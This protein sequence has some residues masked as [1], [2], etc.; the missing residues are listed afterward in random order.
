MNLKT[1]YKHGDIIGTK[2]LVH[3]VVAGGVG[4]VYFCLDLD[5]Q[6]P[7][8]LKTFQRQFLEEK[9]IADLFVNE[10]NIWIDL[11]HH[12]N[13]VYCISVLRM[14]DQVFI[15]LEWISNSEKT[16]D[17]TLRGWINEGPFPIRRA[18]DFMID[19]CRGLIHANQIEPSI[20]HCDLKPENIL[21]SEGNVAK[22][23]DWGL[24]KVLEKARSS[25]SSQD[26]TSSRRGRLINYAGIWGTPLYMSPEQWRGE[27]VDVRS[28]IY[29]LGC[30]LYEMLAGTPPFHSADIKILR[31]QHL[32]DD[33]PKL[34]DSKNV[35][36]ALAFIIRR[37]LS[38][39][40]AQRFQNADEFL[41]EIGHFYK[42]AFLEE[43]KPIASGSQMSVLD[44]VNRGAAFDSLG[45]FDEALEQLEKAIQLNPSFS[46][47]Y[48]NRGNVHQRMGQYREAI[49]DYSHAI[50]LD[51][52]RVTPFIN[53]SSAFRMLN[54]Y[55]KALQD[56]NQ[57]VLLSPK[58]SYT[59]FS[60]GLVYAN[61]KEYDQAVKDFSI[62]IELGNQ[63]ARRER[64][65]AFFQLSRFEEALS[66]LA[67]A[68]DD[69]PSDL[70][71]YLVRASIYGKFTDYQRAMDDLS[72]ALQ[73]DPDFAEAYLAR[74]SLYIKLNRYQEAIEDLNQAIQRNT[75][76][77]N[78]FYERGLASIA[79]EK[80]DEAI[81]DFTKVIELDPDD[82]DT[83]LSRGNAYDTIHREKEALEDYAAVLERDPSNFLAYLNRGHLHLNAGRADEALQD[84]VMAIKFNSE[85]REAIVNSAVILYKQG[86]LSESLP[87]FEKALQLGFHKAGPYV[88]KIRHDLGLPIE[89]NQPSSTDDVDKQIHLVL[90]D[91]METKTLLDMRNLVKRFPFILTPSTIAK[92]GDPSARRGLPTNLNWAISQR[93][94]WL[95][96][97]YKEKLTGNSPTIAFY[98]EN[99]N[100]ARGLKEEIPSGEV[101]NARLQEGMQLLEEANKL[102]KSTD[103]RNLERAIESADQAFSI[104]KEYSDA[105][106]NEALEI[107]NEIYPKIRKGEK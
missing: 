102:R 8:V 33:P 85:L 15:V 68:L 69:D 46:W 32:N 34:E 72:R 97:I 16:T 61:M 75:A 62:A 52:D 63:E 80:Y 107:V 47:T 22:I 90:H 3:H 25:S 103:M 56:I 54:E 43:P 65:N 105:R 53:R 59:Y 26:P 96:Q 104:F 76:N 1:W 84:Y 30:I 2:F 55:D 17:I 20:V 13:I 12:P 36:P 4:E 44:Y 87:Y 81:S 99:G 23:T 29:A 40:P 79:L 60:R 5:G 58:N 48:T 39:N 57:A 18:L 101:I 21:I 106:M 78:A 24:V 7:I 82:Q 70:T 37:A 42:N 83:Y 19:I 91:F 35:D 38:K 95:E 67:K 94:S 10:A 73:I 14:R 88:H 28:D 50:L 93:V 51:A 77:K 64:A 9:T 74:G 66:D 27:K 6:I 89:S 98:D 71:S 11:G 45:R 49:E 86:K 92:L 100:Q 31:E 41:N